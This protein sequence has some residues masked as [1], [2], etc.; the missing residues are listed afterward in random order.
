MSDVEASL[1]ALQE[2]DEVKDRLR[3]ETQFGVFVVHNKWVPCVLAL[4]EER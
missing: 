4:V 1:N 2:S 3:R